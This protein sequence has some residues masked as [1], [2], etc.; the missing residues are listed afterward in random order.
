MGKDNSF[1][2]KAMLFSFLIMVVLVAGCT[3]NSKNTLNTDGNNNINNNINNKN[4][5]APAFKTI[6]TGS[7]DSGDTTVDL[8]PAGIKNGKFEVD[9]SINTH[10]VDLS[11]FDLM[12]II[13]LEY[14]G[15]T[16]K[17]VSAPKLSGH[18]SSGTLIFDTGMEIKSFKII[19]KGIPA[20]EERVFEWR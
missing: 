16:I 8:T 14:D 6:S 4:I 19:I 18:H 13:L 2:G 5:I 9:V 17:P 15:K 20:V 10:S 1:V 11:Q 12:K 3:G 7:L